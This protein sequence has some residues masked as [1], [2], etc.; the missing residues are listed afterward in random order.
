M[1]PLLI[2]GN[3]KS[4][5][6][7]TQAQEWLEQVRI[8]HG[9]SHITVILCAPFTSLSVLQ[10]NIGN[11]KMALE[12]GAQNVSQFDA[13][14]YTGEIS[15]EQLKEV[16]SWVIVG[17]SERRNYFK[18][19]EEDLKKKIQQAKKVGLK[20]LYCVPDAAASPLEGVDAVAYEP[21]GAIG[22][23]NADSFQNAEQ[24]CAQIKA[25]FGKIP[26]LYGGS[27]TPENARAFVDQAHIDGLLVGKASLEAQEFSRLLE[28][29]GNILL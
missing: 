27:V 20:V 9:I 12:L 11:R 26:V 1:K 19:S 15:A 2:V 17:H 7:N 22:T 3:W 14:P 8:P 28:Q 25:R 10:W 18:E 24:V 16:V 23:G 6:T 13:G 5:K 29:V 21:E 4:N